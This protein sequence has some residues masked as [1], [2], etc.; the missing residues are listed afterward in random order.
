MVTIASTDKHVLLGALHQLGQL[1]VIVSSIGLFKSDTLANAVSLAFIFN[2]KDA[3]VLVLAVAHVLAFVLKRDL[4]AVAVAVAVVIAISHSFTVAPEVAVLSHSFTVAPE[5]AVLSA[6]VAAKYVKFNNE[7]PD[8][9][10]PQPLPSPL[11]PELLR[12]AQG[13]RPR[14]RS[15]YRSTCMRAPSSGSI[16]DSHY[17]HAPTFFWLYL[18]ASTFFFAHTF[19]DELDNI[20]SN[21]L[22]SDGISDENNNLIECN[23]AINPQPSAIVT[24]LSD[25]AVRMRLSAIVTRLSDFAVRMRLAAI[26]TRLSDFAVR[27]RLSAI[28]TRLSDFAVRMRL[29]AI[30]TRLSDLR[31]QRNQRRAPL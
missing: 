21:F 7:S 23:I 3:I 13:P 17:L 11:P 9:Q 14:P 8:L 5:A 26:V 19:D 24:R 10:P 27:M 12:H 15:A 4:V 2:L 16:C 1:L 29:A 28:V 20:S 6:P 31:Q 18:H 22:S 25:F 30:V